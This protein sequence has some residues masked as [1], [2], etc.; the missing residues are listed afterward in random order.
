MNHLPNESNAASAATSAN[1]GCQSLK[2]RRLVIAASLS[3]LRYREL[4]RLDELGLH[5]HDRVSRHAVAQSELIRA[6]PNDV[7]D[8]A[9][10][11]PSVRG[12]GRHGPRRRHATNAK[13]QA[14]GKRPR[15]LTG[16]PSSRALPL[17]ARRRRPLETH[18]RAAT[19]EVRSRIATVERPKRETIST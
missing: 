18:L 13:L 16:W 4:R 10:A 1:V 12:I 6:A 15:R 2:F 11:S 3:Q 17:T 14:R 5:A 9:A 19:H 8:V 7:P